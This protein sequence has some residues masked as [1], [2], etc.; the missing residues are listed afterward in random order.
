MTKFEVGRTYST[1]SVCDHNC[2]FSYTVTR[3]TDK[4]VWL[5]TKRGKEVKRRVGPAYHGESEVIYP[6]GKYSMC[7]VLFAER[8]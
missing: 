6:E 7:P 3:R 2:I 1:R 5:T 8:S 4:T